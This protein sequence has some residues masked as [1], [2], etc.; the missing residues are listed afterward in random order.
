MNNFRIPAE[1]QPHEATWIG[2]P[3]NKSDW[4]GKFSPIPWVYGEI[5]RYISYGEKVRIIVEDKNHQSKAEK[6]LKAVEANDSNIEF[7]KLKTNR[8][9][10][11]DS[12]PVFVKDVDGNINTIQFRFNAW[13]KYNNYKKDEKLP[14]FISNKFNL[15][16]VIAEHN[17]KHVFLRAEVLT[18]MEMELY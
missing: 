9:W 5:A 13:A 10:M 1:W 2:W 6:V 4:P 15:N 3:H 14:E 11:R 18:V 17:G 7:Y 8:G 16:K 12:S